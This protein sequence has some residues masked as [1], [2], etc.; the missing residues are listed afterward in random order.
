M[1]REEG[2]KGCG[3]QP[4][5]ALMGWFGLIL[6]HLVAPLRLQVINRARGKKNPVNVYANVLYK[7]SFR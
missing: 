1:E 5:S 4:L 7:T 6:A 2:K 3:L